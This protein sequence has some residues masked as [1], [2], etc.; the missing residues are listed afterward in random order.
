MNAGR[1]HSGMKEL[2]ASSDYERAF[3]GL[4]KM[5]T[6]DAKAFYPGEGKKTWQAWI[7]LLSTAKERKEILKEFG[8]ASL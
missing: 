7:Y 6:G 1:K 3:L 5:E 8:W 4:R 2:K